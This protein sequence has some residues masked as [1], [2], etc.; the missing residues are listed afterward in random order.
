MLRHRRSQDN[1]YF[2]SIGNPPTAKKRSVLA[3]APYDGIPPTAPVG[4]PLAGVPILR[5]SPSTIV[6]AVSAE[7]CS[8]QKS[9][10]LY[11]A[12]EGDGN[13]ERKGKQ[14]NYFR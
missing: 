4:T 2:P 1:H 9:I 12:I 6:E 5:T 8:I 14:Q 11:L 3:D 7:T 13:W 10:T